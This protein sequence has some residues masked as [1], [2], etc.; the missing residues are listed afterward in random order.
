MRSENGTNFVCGNNELNL[1]IKQVNQTKLHN[2]SNHQNIEWTFN[3]PASPWMGEVQ[4]PIV[5]SVK[6]VLKAIVKDRILTYEGLQTFLYEVESVLNGR[7]LTSINN[8]TSDID[9]L[10]PN[11][12]LIGEASPNQ[13]SG[14]FREHE[15][16]LRRK[17]RSVQA[18]TEMLWRRQLREYLLVLSVRRKENSKS[19]NF[20]FGCLVIVMMKDVSR[21]QW[22]MG[23]VLETYGGSNDLVRVVK[24]NTA[25]G[26]SDRTIIRAASKIA[27]L[28]TNLD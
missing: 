13:N 6:T 18:A 7:P 5:K 8:D 23:R 22:S 27:L 4:Q 10:T 25:S 12:L 11:H 16:S 19:R 28:E 9:L 1:C 17:W 15:V 26:E 24:L 21:L 3:P 14:Y 20:E 2:F